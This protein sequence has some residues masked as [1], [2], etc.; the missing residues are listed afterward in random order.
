MTAKENISL[1]VNCKLMNNSDAILV[2]FPEVDH[3]PP[4]KSI[5]KF[6]ERTSYMDKLYQTMNKT[7]CLLLVEMKNMPDPVFKRH[8]TL[9]KGDQEPS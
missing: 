4:N 1:K 5:I 6:I 3:P 9:I 2:I 8:E 7:Q